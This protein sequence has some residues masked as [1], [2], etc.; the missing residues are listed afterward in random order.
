MPFPVLISPPRSCVDETHHNWHKTGRQRILE[1]FNQRSGDRLRP[2]SDL[3]Y[4]VRRRR[5]SRRESDEITIERQR[6]MS[7]T[8]PLPRAASE[9]R[10]KAKQMKAI[11][12]G[13][14]A[15]GTLL[16]VTHGR[17]STQDRDFDRSALYFQRRCSAS[18]RSN[19]RAS[20]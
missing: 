17:R 14:D 1:H 10:P 12:D 4:Q 19:F 2:A 9:H 15:R 6:F 13:S 3:D 8:A 18:N 20:T 7:F 5:L 16:H 11:L